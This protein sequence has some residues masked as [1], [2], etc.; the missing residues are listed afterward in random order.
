ML[1]VA[2]AEQADD[3]DDDE[4]DEA[5]DSTNYYAVRL[6]LAQVG[7]VGAVVVCCVAGP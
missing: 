4:H 1:A 6:A 5:D 2:D 3:D 7:V